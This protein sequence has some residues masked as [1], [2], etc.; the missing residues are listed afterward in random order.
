MHTL[1]WLSRTPSIS[2]ISPNHSSQ[3][4]S[5]GPSHHSSHMHSPGPSHH[6]S[7]MHLPGTS[8]HSA[9]MPSLSPIPSHHS[10]C[11][12]TAYSYLYIPSPFGYPHT[13]Q[14]S[15]PHAAYSLYPHTIHCSCCTC[16]TFHVLLTLFAN[17]TQTHC[18][19]ISCDT[20]LS[21]S[22]CKMKTSQWIWKTYL[23]MM[24]RSDN[25]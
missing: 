3:M 5:P 25:M 2:P 15:H 17:S 13:P 8:H 24:A 7:H 14:Y 16:P 6:S 10:S 18:S 12:Y 1:T 22:I 19:F 23:T 11:M 4:H 9:Y 21:P 20:N